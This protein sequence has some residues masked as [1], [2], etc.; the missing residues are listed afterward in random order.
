MTIARLLEVELF[1]QGI[2]TSILDEDNTR[3]CINCDLD[4]TTEGRNENIRRVAEIS[5]LLNDA[6]VVVI[7]HLFLLS[8]EIREMVHSII[9]NNCF[10]EIFIS[11][12][13][14][15]CMARAPKGLYKKAL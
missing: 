1:Q 5:R 9:G 8:N 6:D 12:P 10:V 11:T 13:I 7:T 15:T 14:E 4:F 3:Q 2:N